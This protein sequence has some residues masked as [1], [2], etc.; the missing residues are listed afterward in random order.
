MAV[1]KEKTMKILSPV[2]DFESL[3]LAVFNGADEVYLGITDFNARA[4]NGFSFSDLPKVVEFAHIYDVKV[5]LAVNILFKNSELNTALELVVKAYN[6]GVDSFIVQDF[7]LITLLYNN[8]PQIEIHASTQMG[9]HNLEGVRFLEKYGVKRVVLARETPLEEIRRIKENSS[10]E[11]EYFA[12]GALCVC[13]SGN[14]Y[15]SSVMCGASGNRGKCKQL[16]RLPYTL[17]HNGKKPKSG[18]LLSAKDFNML[19]RLNDLKNAGVDVIK[20]EG[21]ARRPYYIAVATKS[22]YNA[23]H[24]LPYNNFDLNLAFNRDFTQ[25][26]FNGNGNIISKYNNHIGVPVGKIT[27]VNYGKKFNEIYI[28]SNYPLSPKSAFKVFVDGV[29]KISFTAFDLKEIS[30][31]NYVATTTLK[32]PVGDLNLISD[33]AKEQAELNNIKKVPVEIFLT[34]VV[35]YPLT[36]K[37]KCRDVV[38]ELL[39]ETCDQAKSQPL[40]SADFETTFKKSEYFTPTLNVVTKNVF[41]PK[42]KLNDFRRNVYDELIKLL[43]KTNDKQLEVKNFDTNLQFSKFSDF[44]MIVSQDDKFLTKNI[45]YSPET[46][47][48]QDV[49]KFKEKCEKLKANAFLDLPN[50]ALESDIK[51]LKSIIDTLKIGVV[52]NNY[53]A[54]SLGDN[55]IIGGGLNVY[56]SVAASEFHAPVVCV[57]SNIAPHI[58]FPLMTLRSCPFKCNLGATCNNCPYDN[59]YTLT[60]QNG[61]TLKI[62]RKK[63]STCTFYLSE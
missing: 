17:N 35:G 44:S 33:N 63:L 18:Y 58:Q 46:Y 36:A 27:K 34:A 10:V 24:N 59:N 60:M 22:Y 57:E 19:L 23:L 11:I 3:K 4:T 6:L 28:N 41:L 14:C 52:A 45:I 40:T 2:G 43:T 50:F 31:N 21:R 1:V 29:E 13:F 62:S 5:N 37:V 55:V 39:G 26:Y 9:I 7:G 42:Q 61:K 51:L 8:Y 38:F 49:T 56:N 47:S 16:C 54:L 15:L 48:L 53:Y 30:K 25:G 20:I 32:V 12:H